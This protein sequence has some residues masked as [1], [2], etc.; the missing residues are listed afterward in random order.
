M[1]EMKKSSLAVS[2]TLGTILLLTIAV[3]LFTVLS[4]I[5]LSFPFEPSNPNVNLVGYI[6]DN[7]ITINHNGGEDLGLD[8]KIII[9]INDSNDFSFLASEL[10]DSESVKDN[11][12]NLGENIIVDASKSPIFEILK[13]AQVYLAVVDVNSNSAVLMGVLQE[14]V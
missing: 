9:R 4:S 3:S 2:E 12:W 6:D 10:L 14:A 11:Y 5:V 13:N 7:N 8:T 1:R